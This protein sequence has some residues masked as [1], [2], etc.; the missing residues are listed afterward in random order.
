MQKIIHKVVK[1][2]LGNF[3]ASYQ[4]NNGES[5]ITVFT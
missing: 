3:I 5:V 1:L 2:K 4:H